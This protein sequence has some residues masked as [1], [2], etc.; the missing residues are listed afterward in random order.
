VLEEGPRFRHFT[1]AL[2]RNRTPIRPILNAMDDANAATQLGMS[3]PTRTFEEMLQARSS[4]CFA[5]GTLVH[6]RDGLVPIEQVKTGDW[7]LSQPEATGERAYKRVVRTTRFDDKAVFRVRCTTMPGEPHRSETLIVT[8]NHPFHVRGYEVADIYGN[9]EDYAAMPTGWI[10]A[11]RLVYGAVVELANGE[12]MRSSL[13]DPIWRTRTEG[14]GFIAPRDQESGDVIDMRGATIKETFGEGLTADF[15][16]VEDFNFR[17]GDE[18]LIDK[19]AYKCPVYNFEVEDFHTYYVG[20]AGVWVHNTNCFENSL[21]A[22]K[23]ND[24]LTSPD[25]E[26]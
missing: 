19:W 26:V 12:L 11:D 18:E 20:E 10:R 21:K 6:T 1:P 3:N 14:V 17:Y 22:L 16:G 9:P 4:Y 7:V 13:V 23:R 2:V 5:A 24:K 25:I 8:G 15:F